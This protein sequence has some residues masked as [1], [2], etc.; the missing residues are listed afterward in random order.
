MGMWGEGVQAQEEGVIH[1]S[2]ASGEAILGNKHIFR[3]K[4]NFIADLKTKKCQQLWS[5]LFYFPEKFSENL[6]GI[7]E[8]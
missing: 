1:C 5:V 8:N 4:R 7:R 3:R 2:A 6:T